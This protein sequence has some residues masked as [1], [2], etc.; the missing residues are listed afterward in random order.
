MY[1]GSQDEWEDELV[2]EFGA[3][4]RQYNRIE[5]IETVWGTQFI[6]NVCAESRGQDKQLTAASLWDHLASRKHQN[7]AQSV[8]HSAAA[9]PMLPQSISSELAMADGGM[10]M[11]LLDVERERSDECQRHLAMLAAREAQCEELASRLHVQEASVRS[12]RRQLVVAITASGGT[13]GTALA[14]FQGTKYGTE[15]ITFQA[16]DH[17]VSLPP[18][19]GIEAEGWFYGWTLHDRS[20]N[21]IEKGWY[22]PAFWQRCT[23]YAVHWI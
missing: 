5:Q 13:L 9:L 7:A 6:C 16:G 17:V 20:G 19:D 1:M 10:C 15:Y 21:C 8:W 12:L 2:R 22:P 3:H 4:W 23:D 11:Q 14:P 18:P